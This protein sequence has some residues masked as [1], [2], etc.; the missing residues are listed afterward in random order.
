MPFALALR[1]SLFAHKTQIN[2]LSYRLPVGRYIER[3][4]I[5][6][7]YVCW[8]TIDRYISTNYRPCVERYIYRHYLKYTRSRKTTT[9]IAT[10]RWRN[11][12]FN[13]LNNGLA[14]VFSTL[15][16]TKPSLKKQEHEITYLCGK[17]GTST[18][19]Y[20]RFLTSNRRQHSMLCWR[21]NLS[22]LA[23]MKT[24]SHS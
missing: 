16:V 9:A 12:R 10:R 6:R 18:T 21:E 14:R 1:F 4:S 5:N 22:P 23:T 17:K 24:S 3:A 2:N 11:K 8:L 15:Y 19:N 7:R 13:D 20:S